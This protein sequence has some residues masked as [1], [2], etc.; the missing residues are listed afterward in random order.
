[1]KWVLST[2]FSTSGFHR[3]SD[4]LLL[5]KVMNSVLRLLP[6]VFV[7][8]FLISGDSRR[9]PRRRLRGEAREEAK[10]KEV[11]KRRP[12]RRKLAEGGQEFFSR[13]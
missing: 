9:R 2:I 4:L 1:M 13:P 10:A 12:K 8:H 5:S 11:E 6:G 3:N 7:F